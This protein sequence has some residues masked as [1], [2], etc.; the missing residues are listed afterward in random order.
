MGT[1]LIHNPLVQLYLLWVGA[2]AIAV[3][4]A[5][6]RNSQQRS[7]APRPGPRRVE[8]RE[9]TLRNETFGSRA[10]LALVRR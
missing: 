7:A 1:I 8:M 2:L 6:P 3:I 10:S 5:R 9:R 4:C